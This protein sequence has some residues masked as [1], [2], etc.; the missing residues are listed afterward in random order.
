M[1]RLIVHKVLNPE[2]RSLPIFDEFNE[3]ADRIRVRAYSL[4]KRH[5][6]GEGRDL[7]DWLAAEREICWP[8]AELVEDDQ[9]VFLY[10]CD[11]AFELPLFAEF[12]HVGDQGG[13]TPEA[14]ALALGTGGEPQGG[15]HVTLAGARVADRRRGCCRAEGRYA[16]VVHSAGQSR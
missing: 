3:I 13:R 14:H 8:S 11:E 9:V 1:S 12:Q 5:G 16:G 6:P 2:D 15:S 10:L 7:D 4:S